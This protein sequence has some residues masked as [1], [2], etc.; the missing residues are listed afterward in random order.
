[1]SGCRI[2]KIRYKSAPYLAEI[3]PHMR[4]SS[5]PKLMHEFVDKI[6]GYYEKDGMAGFCVVAWGFDGNYSRGTRIHEDSYIGITMM[7]SMVADILRR[8][9]MQDVVYDTL[10]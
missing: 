2:G 5:F 6:G 3:V 8:D 10:K 4:G 1:M 9:T 7:P